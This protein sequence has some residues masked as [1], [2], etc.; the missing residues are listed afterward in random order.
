LKHSNYIT[1]SVKR[2]KIKALIDTGA[3][4]TCISKRIVDKI[5]LPIEPFKPGELC[6]L[7]AANATKLDALGTVN[8]DYNLNGLIIPFVTVVI[9]NLNDSCILGSDFLNAT[10]ANIDF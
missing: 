7:F 6:N 3:G 5:N 2:L 4:T 8:V 1:V 10:S 9:A